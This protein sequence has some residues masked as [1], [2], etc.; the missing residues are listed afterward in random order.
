[1]LLQFTMPMY[2]PEQPWLA[3][4]AIVREKD[5]LRYCKYPAIIMI[6]RLLKQPVETA[7]IAIFPV[8]Q[9][10]Q[11][12]L[13]QILL[14]M[15]LED[16]SPSSKAMLNS[17]FALA[18]FIRDGNKSHTARYKLAALDYLMVSTEQGI[19]CHTSIKHIAAGII[20]C[21]FEVT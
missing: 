20:L 1:M 9:T 21:I 19:T 11:S 2:R 18:A 14:R 16:E 3:S 17:I 4:G 6:S 13:C 15:A 5:L 12:K 7:V 8:L 10:T